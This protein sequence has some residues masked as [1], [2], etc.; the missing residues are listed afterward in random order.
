MAIGVW[1]WRAHGFDLADALYRSLALFEINNDAYG[2][3]FGLSDWR[4]RIGRWTGAG[5][6]FSG[7]LA[8]AALLR[9]HLA[10]A[11]ARWTKQ[12]VVIIGQGSLASTAF[13]AA[14]RA[15]RSVLWLGAPAFSASGFSTMALLWPA[16]NSSMAVRERSR[17]ADHI[18]IAGADDAEALLLAR[19]ARDTSPSAY[20]TVLMRDVRLAE[21]AAATLNRARTRV[22]SSAAI[23]ARALMVAEPPFLIARGAGHP[24]IHALIVGFGE[25]GQAIARDVIVN[26]RTTYLAAPR[27][28]VIDPAAS[29]LESAW[30]VRA[31]EIDACAECAFVEG[32]VGARAVRPTP[33]EIAA[34]LSGGGP[35][36]AAYVCVGDDS[37]ALDAAAMLQALF[38]WVSIAAPPIFVRL[39]ETSAVISGVGPALDTLIPFGDLDALLVASE[40]MSDRPDFAARAYADAYRSRLPR[41][42]Q[43]DAGNNSA[44]PWDSL[45]ET[46]RQAN[47]DAVAHIPAKLASAGV[48][49]A[50]WKGAPGL[51]RL[52]P[53]MRLFRTDAEL[54]RLAALEHERWMAQRRMD[55]WRYGPARDDALRLHPS[56]VPYEA[57][58]P[59][60]QEYDRVYVRQTQAI[61][62]T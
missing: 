15:R 61:C 48:D 62:E 36:T 34:A 39:R 35:I 3:G 27:L 32:Q 5:A 22:L 7:L 47:R 20:L 52:P 57:L 30:R 38:R 23:A 8:V 58:D 44:R 26:C 24:R 29:A 16:R 11:M 17:R 43:D 50:L 40:F 54:E 46:Y 6:V 56:L 18:L 37:G 41:A 9:E 14:R 42:R 12:S 31:P 2:S 53:G 10:T 59:E 21:D 28:T 19:A 13:E 4:F 45:D 33:G 25:V 51:P 1:G 55:G 60:T 49:P